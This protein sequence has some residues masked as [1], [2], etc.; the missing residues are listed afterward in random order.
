MKLS[1][2]EKTIYTI[3]AEGDGMTLD[4]WLQSLP[5]A[6]LARIEADDPDTFQALMIS[7]A[8]RMLD[9]SARPSLPKG[10]DGEDYRFKIC[11]EC[12]E[13]RYQILYSPG[14]TICK[15]CYIK[16]GKSQVVRPNAEIR[17]LD[18]PEEEGE[19]CRRCSEVKPP[20]EFSLIAGVCTACMMAAKAEAKSAM[21]MRNRVAQTEKEESSS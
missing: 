19:E 7:F 2:A 8:K 14:E 16:K 21:A 15:H 13:N 6:E 10:E 4:D 12:G 11:D 17:E 9:P 5:S 20:R 18:T 3:L 1:P